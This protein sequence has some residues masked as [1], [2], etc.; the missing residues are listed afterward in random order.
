MFELVVIVICFENIVLLF[1]FLD[2]DV[3]FVF[4][5]IF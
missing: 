1:L 3:L 4:D 5:L 2:S